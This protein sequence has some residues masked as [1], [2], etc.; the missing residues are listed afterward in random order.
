MATR[1]SFGKEDI[2]A[3][4]LAILTTGLYRDPLDT[5]REYIQNAIDAECRSLEI[6]IDPDTVSVTD[7][8][9]G[10]DAEK[11]RRAIRFGISDKNPLQNVGF[12]GIGLYSAF[13]LCEKLTIHTRSEKDAKGHRIS[14]DFKGIRDALMR[15]Q[16]RRK[17]DLPPALYLEKLLETAVHVDV[18]A[19]DGLAQHG[20]RA[21]LSG[22]LGDVYKR[23][24]SWGDVESYLQNTVPLPFHPAFQHKGAIEKR[25]KDEAQRIIPL[26]LQVLVRREAIYRPYRNEMFTKGTGHPPAFF[27]VTDGK[28]TFAVAWACINDARAVLK[29]A[30]LRGLLIKKFGFSIADRNFLE[31]FFTRTVINRRL[32]GE[33]IVRDPELI[34]NAARSD[35]EHNAARQSFMVAL[36]ALTA[37]LDDWGNKFQQEDKA[38]EV[39]DKTRAR[40]AEINSAL[41]NVTRD[42][43][44]LLTLLR[45][46][47][48]HDKTLKTHQKTL[49]DIASDGLAQTQK[50]LKTDRDFIE[51]LLL[52]KK[53]DQKD[54]EQRIVKSVQQE[55][56]EKNT[57]APEPE[58]ATDLTAVVD[59]YALQSVEDWRALLRYIDEAAL[60]SRLSPE[61]YQEVL[62]AIRD[63]LDEIE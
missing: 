40:A 43:D 62:R 27:P 53:Q 5:L 59:A 2:G 55:L 49:K 36:S 38:R 14:V 24:N 37:A 57:A 58:P 10:M 29:D 16:Q 25:L 6:V 20:T 45:E 41:P 11:A 47:D 34:P 19:E 63:F 28:K 56:A 35:F 30:S 46:I 26:T 54:L 61:D 39:L 8:G 23:L 18:D 50:L 44:R 33:I 31:P 48:T 4:I 21:I 32:T 7:D 60:Q 51:S 17:Q 1:T 15:E 13:N 3:E 12:R 52:K 9:H 42:S 22:L